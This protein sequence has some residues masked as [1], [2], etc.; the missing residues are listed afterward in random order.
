M[1][2]KNDKSSL[3][4][5]H[6][7]NWIKDYKKENLIKSLWFDLKIELTLFYLNYFKK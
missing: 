6:L 1:L 3:I 2:Q 5:K 4:M 7:N